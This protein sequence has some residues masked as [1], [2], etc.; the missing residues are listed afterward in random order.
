MAPY[1]RAFSSVARFGTVVRFLS[2]AE[3]TRVREVWG[4]L[5]IGAGVRVVLA[6]GWLF[7]PAKGAAVGG[8]K[9]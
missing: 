3:K 5:G 2:R 8:G 9:R 4:T 6:G 7:V 1:M